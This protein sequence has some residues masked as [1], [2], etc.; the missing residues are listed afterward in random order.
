MLLNLLL[1][2]FK[3]NHPVAS[4][5]LPSLRNTKQLLIVATTLY[6]IHRSHSITS[7]PV[8]R[9]RIC[10]V[11]SHQRAL[12]ET[13][14]LITS[15]PSQS[16]LALLHFFPVYG[17]NNN[18]QSH[19]LPRVA[20]LLPR[21]LMAT[22]HHTVFTSPNNLALPAHLINTPFSC[23]PDQMALMSVELHC[24][25]TEMN[26]YLFLIHAY[27]LSNCSVGSAKGSPHHL[28]SPNTGFFRKLQKDLKSMNLLCQK[29]FFPCNYLY[30]HLFHPSLFLSFCPTDGIFPNFSAVATQDLSNPSTPLLCC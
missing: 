11:I 14:L 6:G 4:L 20:T 16:F 8:W 29:A 24:H 26:Y 10:S 2:T 23:S 30:I 21:L 7:F 27:C 9:G 5:V 18:S 19:V 12:Q 3:T 17:G 15:S 13:L 22:L 1:A 25:F 28:A